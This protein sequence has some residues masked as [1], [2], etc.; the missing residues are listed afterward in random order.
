[1]L[2]AENMTSCV[3]MVQTG[4]SSDGEGGQNINWSPSATNDVLN[5]FDAAI[6]EDSSHETQIAMQRGWNGSFTIITKRTN[7]LKFGD[8][9]KRIEDGQMFRVMDDAVRKT[10]PSA[11]LDMR[12]CKGEMVIL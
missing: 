7:V 4:A 8:V 6:V 3:L 9:I 2:L 12:A 5:T 10:P 11:G 1:M